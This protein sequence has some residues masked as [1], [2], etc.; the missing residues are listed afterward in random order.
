MLLFIVLQENSAISVVCC[1]SHSRTFKKTLHVFQIS[2]IGSLLAMFATNLYIKLC[3]FLVNGF[4]FLQRRMQTKLTNNICF[5]RCS[6][7]TV[8]FFSF[9]FFVCSVFMDPRGLMINCNVDD[10][11]D[12]WHAGGH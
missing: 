5:T 3:E 2:Q 9:S 1:E 10:R 11:N 4:Q 12:S 8:R 7:F 6:V